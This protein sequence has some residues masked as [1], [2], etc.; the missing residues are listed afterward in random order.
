MVF[1]VTGSLFT[2]FHLGGALGHATPTILV[3]R[4]LAGIFGSARKLVS[5]HCHDFSNGHVS[6][7]ALTNAGGGLSDMWIARERGFPA[8]L[9]GTAPWMG[10]GMLIDFRPRI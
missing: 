7:T 1:V 6:V 9:F 4:T 8:S 3:T 2:L 5:L 10:P